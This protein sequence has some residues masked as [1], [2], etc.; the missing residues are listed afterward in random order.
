MRE[1]PG[2]GHSFSPQKR[3]VDR[4]REL[5]CR[6]VAKQTCT[7]LT[8]RLEWRSSSSTLQF[9]PFDDSPYAGTFDRKKCSE[10]DTNRHSRFRDNRVKADTYLGRKFEKHIVYHILSAIFGK[11]SLL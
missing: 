8:S 9:V 7:Q 10:I 11:V 5:C 4:Q 2:A 3:L 1:P 6:R